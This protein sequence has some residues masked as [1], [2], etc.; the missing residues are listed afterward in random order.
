MFQCYFVVFFHESMGNGLRLLVLILMTISGA[1][2]GR[3]VADG[4]F[5]FL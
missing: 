1:V 4:H 3:K 2:E 5:L